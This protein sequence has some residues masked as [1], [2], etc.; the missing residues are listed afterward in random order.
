MADQTPTALSLTRQ[1]IQAAN[2]GNADE[3]RRLLA[4]AIQLNPKYERA[5]LWF[6]SLARNDGERRYCLERAIDANDKS[7]ARDAARR[8]RSV[9]EKHPPEVD[10]LAE[11]PA[12]ARLIE[13]P[14]PVWRRRPRWL[15]GVSGALVA[16][17]VLGSLGI[18][19][20]RSNRASHVY[21]ALVAGMSGS[22]AAYGK[23]MAGSVQMY[24]DQVNA[25]GGVHGHPVSLLVYDD[26]DDPAEAR[27]RAEEIVKDGRALLV[28][29]HRTSDASLAA[30]PVY[31]QAHMPAISATATA[32]AVTQGSPWYFSTIFDNHDE[33]SLL[34]AYLRD[35][36]GHKEASVI[37]GNR[38]YGSNLFAGFEAAYTQG[39]HLKHVIQLNSASGVIDQATVS[40]A[41]QE[42]QAD[43]NPGPVVLAMSPDLAKQVVIGFKKANLHPLLLGSDSL[44]DV[45]FLDSFRDQPEEKARP[46]AFT[47]GMYVATP[48]MI[49]GL[50]GDGLR[51]YHD[52]LARFGSEPSWRGLTSYDAAIAAVQ[53]LR[54]T[55]VSGPPKDAGAARQ[56][57]RDALASFKN[58]DNAI[59]GLTGPLY[60][61][62]AGSAV[63][64][65]DVGIAKNQD[66][67]S[68]PV[69]LASFGAS[70]G[71]DFVRKLAAGDLIQAGS[72][73]LVRKRIVYTGVNMNE[74]GD[75][76]Q[77]AQT[78]SADFFLWLKYIG[79][80]DAANITFVNAVD[81]SLSLGEPLRSETTAGVNYRLYRVNSKFKATLDFRNFPFDKQDLTI[82]IQ[83][84]TLSSAEVVYVAD[85]VL[86]TQPQS[87]RLTSGANA[88]QSISS[89]DNWQPIELQ[90]YRASVGN[91]SLLGGPQREVP[92]SGIEYSQFVT[93][94]SIERNLSSFLVK[95]L[96]PLAL[97]ALVT[98]VSLFFP[99][100]QTG[101]R[102]SFGI[103]GILTGAV[104]LS[105]VTG[106]LPNVEYT[107]AIEWGYYAFI[108]LSG[109]CLLI[110]LLGDRYYDDRRT[111]ALNR[112]A[113]LSRLYYPA[114]VI[115][116]VLIYYFKF[117]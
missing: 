30:S 70:A 105:G 60:F 41:I 42:L 103:T 100:N 97:L 115:A 47:D 63:R 92:A 86:L 84:K 114:F 9:P 3:A 25:H 49:D 18:V 13:E 8:L 85:S 77:Q 112:L 12:P 93:D 6:A 39:A 44:G 2:D 94:L 96:L 56:R 45:T 61:S 66:L 28:I 113:F 51:W 110:G 117:R 48:A 1:A 31:Q 24:L 101:A 68:A 82:A 111:V 83:N 21:V 34:A 40:P 29:G 15:I 54:D 89:I 46:G 27:L 38:T 87:E 98:Y 36:L 7:V 72:G 81:P 20:S 104:L 69:Q 53:V 80:D 22:S 99:A 108:F 4:E 26:K 116:V 90:F 32:D 106:S 16:L 23:E 14:V 33:G 5:W 19:L 88:S 76:D 75:L 78:F 91:T 10:Q 55:G 67:T 59:P 17:I 79:S 107:V 71:P 43:P 37:W 50:T 73:Y 62:S 74:V 65:I 109:T 58:R 52:F 11:P 35:V 95:N 64:S 102:V 57:I